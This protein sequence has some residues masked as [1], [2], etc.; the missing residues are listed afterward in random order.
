MKR[1]FYVAVGTSK[2][3]NKYISIILDLGYRKVFL[4]SRETNNIVLCSEVLGV[5]I[6]EL[7]ELKEGIYPISEVK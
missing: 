6:P 3:G 1:D 4:S 5:G 7:L 2:A